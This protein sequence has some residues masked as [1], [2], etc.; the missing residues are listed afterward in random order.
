MTHYTTLLFDL[1]GTIS[2]SAPGILRSVRYGLDAVGIHET[3][4][5]KLR[6]FIGPPLNTQMKK[7]Y[8]MKD[9]DIVTAITKFRELYEEKGALFDCSP[10]AGI[11]ELLSLAK[12]AGYV[13]A[14][15]SSKPEP[16]V[17]RII[18]NFGFTS[19]FDV[20]CGS[21]PDDELNQNATMSQKARIIAK[22]LSL[23]CEKGHDAARLAKETV[24]IGDT[25][26]DVDGA[27]DNH[28]PC[29]AVSFGY[30]SREELAAH[31]AD[32][33]ADTVGELRELLGLETGHE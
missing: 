23:L 33:I 19:Y 20:I 25:G 26:Y 15:S 10:Y 12:A 2:E 13:L 11:G 29:I 9:D 32:A 3:D 17:K 28:L 27:H 5:K 6:T 22:T 24:M 16:F 1:D 30:S 31:G 14:V 4:E 18:E 7:L 8:G 21:D